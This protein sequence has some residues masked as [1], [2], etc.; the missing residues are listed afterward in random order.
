ML[1]ERHEEV[2]RIQRARYDAELELAEARLALVAVSDD[3]PM[4]QL[5][6]C[7]APEASRQEGDP[8]PVRDFLTV[9][10]AA[11]AFGVSTTTMRRWLR[12][13]LPHDE[14]DPRNP[15]EPSATARVVERLSDRKQRLIVSQLDRTRIA[16]EVMRT[17]KQMVLHPPSK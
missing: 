7:V 13:A 3:K 16:P 2:A 14:G 5:E 6:A 12:G 17:I 10:E 11:A 4:P 15:W 1:E 8:E 9:A